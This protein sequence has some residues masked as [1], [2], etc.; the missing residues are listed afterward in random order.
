LTSISDAPDGTPVDVLPESGKPFV[1]KD[2]REEL[3]KDYQRLIL[4]VSQQGV[5]SGIL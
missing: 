1:L 5:L 2:Y 4:Y 3:M